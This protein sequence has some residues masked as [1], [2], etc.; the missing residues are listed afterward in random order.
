MHQ[1]APGLYHWKAQHPNIGM[2]VSSYYD[3]SSGTLLDPIEPPE[4][5][6]SI[7]AATPAARIILT[8]RHHHRDAQAFASRFGCEVLSNAAGLH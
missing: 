4:G 1:L 3:A 2:E 5:V 7:P 6:D 8:N